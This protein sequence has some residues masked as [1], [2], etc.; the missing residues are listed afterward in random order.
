MKYK[1]PSDKKPQIKLKCWEQTPVSEFLNLHLCKFKTIKNICMEILK[2][3]GESSLWPK[4]IKV[5]ESAELNNLG[6]YG[7]VF[8]D[9]WEGREKPIPYLGVKA[10]AQKRVWKGGEW[11]KEMASKFEKNWLALPSYWS[12]TTTSYIPKLFS[13]ANC[14]WTASQRGSSLFWSLLEEGNL[15]ALYPASSY[16]RSRGLYIPQILSSSTC[17]KH[18]SIWTADYLIETF[19]VQFSEL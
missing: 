7:I 12:R 3:G 4:A 14:V 1:K 13:S 6:I 17:Y 9:Q 2:W 5:K 10:W 19:S 15:M 16:Q 11:V 18:S 8:V